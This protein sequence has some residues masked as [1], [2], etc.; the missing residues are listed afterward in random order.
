MLSRLYVGSYG[1]KGRGITLFAFDP[2]SG[3]LER[4]DLTPNEGGPSWLC[5]AGDRLYAADEQADRL[6]SYAIEADGALR[7]LDQR[8]SGGRLPVHLALHPAGRQLSVAHYGSAAVVVWAL[9]GQGLPTARLAQQSMASL[10]ETGPQQAVLA[11]PGSFAHSGHDGPHVHQALY[12][13]DG[14]HLLATDLGLDLLVEWDLGD[15]GALAAPRLWHASPGAGP[16]HAV[17]H[18]RRD[19]LLY[20]LGEE[21]STLAWLRRDAAGHWQ[22]AAE[23]ASLPAGFAGT[24]FAS[25]LLAAPDGRH[26]YALNRLHDSIAVFALAPDGRPQL[27]HCEWTRGSYPRSACLDASGRWLLV[28]NQGSDQLTVF[29]LDAADGCP[30]F[31]EQWVAVPSPAA[32]LCLPAAI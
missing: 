2:R 27:R 12:A 25:G 13:P 26:L 16:R 29:A 28:G 1:P 6:S 14:R 15:D 24:S 19:D 4:Q 3:R 20:V 30:H 5:S 32:L 7:L 9:D 18:P 17:F 23:L 11:P 10:G 21:S 22:T 8:S 31:A